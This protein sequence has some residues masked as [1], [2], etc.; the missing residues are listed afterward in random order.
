MP[1]MIAGILGIPKWAKIA[2]GVAALIAAFFLWLHFHDRGVIE[3]ERNEREAEVA[4]KV[5]KADRKAGANKADRDKAEGKKQSELERQADEAD[6]NGD[7]PLD[8]VWGGLF[9]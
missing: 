4:K 3:N 9:D 5:S 6:R 8:A 1:P 7:S 2:L